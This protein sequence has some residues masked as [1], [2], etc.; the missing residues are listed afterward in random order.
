MD[1][2]P[3]FRTTVGAACHGDR[4]AHH[5]LFGRNLPVLIAYLRKRIG[6][7]IARAESAEDL[8]QSVCREVLADLPALQFHREDQFRAYLFLQARRKLMDRARYYQ[9]VGRDPG[10]QHELAAWPEQTSAEPTPSRIAVAKEE[11]LL[12][13]QAMGELPDNQR[14]AVLLS[15]V[16]GLSYG[17]IAELKGQTESAIRGLVARGLSR[18][19]GMARRRGLLPD[20]RGTDAEGC[21]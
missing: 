2:G 15:R 18:L 12:A 5:T 4:D 11:L 1:P 3:S 6:G 19:S 14:E 17:E 7:A 8:A 20:D 10:K 16:A 21:G 9:V 13:E